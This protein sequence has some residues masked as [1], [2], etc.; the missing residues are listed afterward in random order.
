[1]RTGIVF[2]WKLSVPVRIHWLPRTQTGPLARNPSK[3]R[4]GNAVTVQVALPGAY[5]NVSLTK[6]RPPLEVRTALPRATLVAPARVYVSVVAPPPVPPSQFHVPKSRLTSAV[7]TSDGV[8]G[9]AI[10]AR[11]VVPSASASNKANPK[12]IA[13]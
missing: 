12:R 4:F 9:T 10:C 6:P 1:M 11:P 5:T 8:P 13:F 3:K 7:A 2:F